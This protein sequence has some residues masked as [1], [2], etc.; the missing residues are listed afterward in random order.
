MICGQPFRLLLLQKGTATVTPL[1]V[2][3]AL[4]QPSGC[5][6]A[7]AF[8]EKKGRQYMGFALYAAFGNKFG[9]DSRSQSARVPAH[10]YTVGVYSQERS[11]NTPC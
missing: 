8:V 9:I 2:A 3:A 11:M 4:P 6:T 10:A 1:S 5:E 7:A